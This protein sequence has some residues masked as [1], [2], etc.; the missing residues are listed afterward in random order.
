MLVLVDFYSIAIDLIFGIRTENPQYFLAW[1]SIQ[2]V[3]LYIISVE[4]WLNFYDLDDCFMLGEWQTS[5]TA[6]FYQ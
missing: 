3:F 4:Q 5:T 2:P 1:I 6:I